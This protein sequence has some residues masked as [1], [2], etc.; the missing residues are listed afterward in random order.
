MTEPNSTHRA[1]WNGDSGQIWAADADRRD[2][3]LAPVLDVLLSAARIQP[4]ENILDVG[5]GCGATTLAAA[6]QLTTGTATGLDLSHP[7]LQVARQ[8]GERRERVS[9]VEADA[10]T[11]AFESASD[12][13]ISR[14]GTMFFDDPVAAFGNLR[15]AARDGGR[16]CIATWQ[17]LAA[18]DWLLVPEAVLDRYG[19]QPDVPGPGMFS[20]SDPA[21][22]AAM[23]SGAGWA[24]PAVEPHQVVLRIGSDPADAADYLAGTGSVRRVLDTIDP[25]QRSAAL[26]DL[27]AALNDHV[28]D[29]V[30]LT[31]GINIVQAH[32]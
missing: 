16:L 9:F 11:F 14:F 2:R 21:A 5:C 10:Q 17:P 4:A 6:A 24:R 13:I 31:A 3:I 27:A 32:A 15:R 1:N 8:R 23:L 19:P 20:Q 25:G 29:G 30:R 28:S 7:M 12:L 26:A 22:M 18:N